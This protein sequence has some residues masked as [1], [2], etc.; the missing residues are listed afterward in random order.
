MNDSKTGRWLPADLSG[1]VSGQLTVV[2]DTGEKDKWGYKLWKARCTCGTEIVRGSGQFKGAQAIRSCG[3]LKV[4]R[5]PISKNGA[6]VRTIWK[7]YEKSAAERGLEFAL[8]EEQARDLISSSCHYCGIEPPDKTLPNLQ[9][10]YRRHGID[11]ADNAVGYVLSNCVPCC[12]A[13]NFAKS[14]KSE[15][16]FRAWVRRA[17]IHMFGGARG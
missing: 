9:G 8:S 10:S 4:G 14:D 6:H 7:S 17:F 1:H 13:C 16:E 12:I 11:R 2:S 3:C 5:K 15:A